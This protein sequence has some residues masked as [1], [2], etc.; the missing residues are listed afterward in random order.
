MDQHSNTIEQ[1]VENC[2]GVSLLGEDELKDNLIKKE[3]EINAVWSF[4]FPGEEKMNITGLV[5]YVG[6]LGSGGGGSMFVGL[7]LDQPGIK[8]MGEIIIFHPFISKPRS[9]L[10]YKDQKFYPNLITSR[11]HSWMM[12]HYEP[13]KKTFLVKTFLNYG[14]LTV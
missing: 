14:L 7:K 13:V 2:F 10:R 11:D 12:D 4:Y 5:K 8:K 3:F 6:K 9:A 1:F